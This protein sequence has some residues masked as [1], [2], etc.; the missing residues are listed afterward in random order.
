MLSLLISYVSLFI[1]SYIYNKH[2]T[3]IVLANGREIKIKIE[4]RVK[5][6]A[7][8]TIINPSVGSSKSF[9]EPN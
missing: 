3:E 9:K 5:H 2:Y 8:D 7:S 1:S 6:M 4:S